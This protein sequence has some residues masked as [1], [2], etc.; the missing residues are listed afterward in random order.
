M[1]LLRDDPRYVRPRRAFL[2]GLA[3]TGSRCTYNDTPHSQQAWA[4]S[5]RTRLSRS[6]APLRRFSKTLTRRSWSCPRTGSTKRRAS[7]SRT[8]RW[9]PPATLTYVARL[10][11]AEAVA[12][13]PHAHRRFLGCQQLKWEAPDVDGLVEFMCQ[14]HGFACVLFWG[15]CCYCCCCCPRW[16]DVPFRSQFTTPG[17][18]VFER[19]PRSLPNHGRCANVIGHLPLVKLNVL[20]QLLFPCFPFPPRAPPFL[21]PSV[22]P[23]LDAG[24]PRLVLQGP[25]HQRHSQAQGK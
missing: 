12:A 20:P 25:A 16:T 5:V 21:R 7:S 19:R 18:T 24:P 4:G 23:G 2:V 22:P 14:K 10:P 3:P 6:T 13:P 8:Q 15:C 1:R 9:R 11:N 17:R